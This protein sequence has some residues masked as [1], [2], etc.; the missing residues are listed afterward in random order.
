MARRLAGCKTILG[1][2]VG[3]L[4]LSWAAAA[5]AA[6]PLRLAVSMTLLSLPIFVAEQQGYF[7][8]AGRRP[9]G[10]SG[11][12]CAF[13]RRMRGLHR[14]QGHGGQRELA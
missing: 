9:G 5:T 7:A 14:G 3:L 4:L 11:S 10:R 8:Q 13:D 12:A 1:A 6:E 2:A